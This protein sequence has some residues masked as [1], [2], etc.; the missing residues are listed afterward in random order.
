MHDDTNRRQHGADAP[1]TALSELT[2]LARDLGLYASTPRTA[3]EAT[4]LA[5]AIRSQIGFKARRLAAR[6]KDII[7]S[8]SH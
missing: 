2:S 8:S 5:S 4:A 6:C 7:S 3:E 1:E